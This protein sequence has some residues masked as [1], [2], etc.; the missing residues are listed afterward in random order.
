MKGLDWGKFY[1]DHGT[2]ADLNAATLEARIKEL[3]LD[4]EV[5]S[6]KGI[7]AYL[8]TGEEKTLNLRQFSDKIKATVFEKQKGKCPV[9]KKTFTIEQME[10]DHIVP[11]H[12]G[13]KTVIGNCQMLCKLD[14]RTKSGK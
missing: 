4:D 8:L 11:W 12:E 1:R 7:Y 9:C 5:D 13:G 14:N 3:L 10:A 2:R 6:K